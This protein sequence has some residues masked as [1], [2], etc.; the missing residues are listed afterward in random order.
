[1]AKREPPLGLV[2]A[3]HGRHFDVE[4][5]DGSVRKCFPRGK[6]AG[7]AVGDFAHVQ[8]QGSDEGVIT[9]L[10]PRRNLLYRSDA[11]RSKQFAANID[12][13]VYVVAAVPAYS[14]DLLG[15]ALVAAHSAGIEPLILLNKGDLPEAD[16]ARARLAG[17]VPEGVPIVRVQALDSDDVARHLAPR[18]AG[19]RSLLLGQSGMGK[20]TLL[21]TLVPEARAATRSH[22]EA[23]GAGRHTTTSTRLYHLPGGGSLI[24]SP[25]F[26]N[27]GLHHLSGE[28]IVQ[29]FPEFREAVE[30]CRY[31]NCSHRHEPGCGVLAALAEG[32][33]AP[34]RHALY[35]RLLDEHEQAV[36]YR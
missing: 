26:Q 3:A 25:G 15:R 17:L 11:M 34:A 12:L 30:H 4:M 10:A 8:L 21:N 28:E 6:K 16:G 24:D 5:P 32:R 18:L 23:L 7:P 13:L 20:S 35:E 31:Y 19:R 27:F 22:S 33:I 14:D 2:V 29:G 9:G 36:S 1:M